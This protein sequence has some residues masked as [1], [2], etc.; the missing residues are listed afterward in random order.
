MISMSAAEVGSGFKAGT[1]GNEFSLWEIWGL[2]ELNLKL[3]MGGWSPGV[4]ELSGSTS[5]GHQW[6]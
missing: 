3:F 4:V 5:H 2:S 1:I 6:L